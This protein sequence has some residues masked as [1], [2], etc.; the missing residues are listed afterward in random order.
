MERMVFS[1]IFRLSIGRFGRQVSLVQFHLAGQEH[2]GLFLLLGLSIYLN[3]SSQMR[4]LLWQVLFHSM[5]FLYVFFALLLCRLCPRY[6][7]RLRI[8]ECVH[9]LIV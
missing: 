7:E 9:N 1:F 5:Y 8:C 4:I 2:G 3:K 6:M